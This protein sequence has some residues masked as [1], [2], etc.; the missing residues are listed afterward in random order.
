MPASPGGA[1]SVRGKTNRC[2]A[3]PKIAV[4]G[5]RRARATRD[6][7]DINDNPSRRDDPKLAQRFIAAATPDRRLSSPGGAADKSCS[8]LPGH[9]P[10]LHRQEPSVLQLPRADEGDEEHFEAAEGFPLGRGDVE[11]AGGRSS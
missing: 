10:A 8:N 2:R 4:H 6:P 9:L 3:P 1:T 7:T 11:C 5:H